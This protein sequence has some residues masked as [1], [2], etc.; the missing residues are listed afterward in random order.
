MEPGAGP[1][2]P[3]RFSRTGLRLRG[4]SDHEGYQH[5]P[6]PAPA[7]VGVGGDGK[8]GHEVIERNRVK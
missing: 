1:P 4:G 7:A 8:G 6:L 5:R 3:G 2:D